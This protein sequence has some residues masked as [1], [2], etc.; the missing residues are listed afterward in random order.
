MAGEKP[1]SDP[2]KAFAERLKAELERQ[3]ISQR[4]LVA[5]A[6]VS[7]QSVTAWTGGKNEPTLS[8]V[9]RLALALNVSVAYLV[10]G[11]TPAKQSDPEVAT[12]EELVRLDL[13]APVRSLAQSAPAFLDLLS[14]AEERVRG[15]RGDAREQPPD[16]GATPDL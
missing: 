9:R 3:K 16:S 2:K 13:A 14:K 11:E 4:Q 1:S 8:Q 5:A 15:A 10:E 7:R 12:L 6:G